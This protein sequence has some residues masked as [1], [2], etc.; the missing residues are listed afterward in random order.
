MADRVRCK[1]RESRSYDVFEITNYNTYTR[2]RDG[3]QLE[4]PSWL[5]FAAKNWNSVRKRRTS[6]KIPQ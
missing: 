1:V 5:I 2:F 4:S 3:P 6:E